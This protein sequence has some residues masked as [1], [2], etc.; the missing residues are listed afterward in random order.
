KTVGEYIHRPAFELFKIDED[1]NESRNLASDPAHAEILAK[2]Q[3][4]LKAIQK[5]FG[6]P[7]IQ[8]WEYE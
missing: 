8:K 7:W 1:P 3:E 4:K 2:Y 6:D 5:E